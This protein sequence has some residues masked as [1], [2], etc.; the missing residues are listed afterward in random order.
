M[1]REMFDERG[2]VEEDEGV[3]GWASAPPEVDVATPTPR[4]RSCT[5]GRR[6]LGALTPKGRSRAEGVGAKAPAAAARR[7]SSRV[8]DH[9]WTSAP[10]TSTDSAGSSDSASSSDGAAGAAVRRPGL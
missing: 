7:R 5:H 1:R 6:R 9:S 3:A 8:P 4:T 2:A 10:C